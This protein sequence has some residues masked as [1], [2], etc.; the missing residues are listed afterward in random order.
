MAPAWRPPEASDRKWKCE[1]QG[2]R[3]RGKEYKMMTL[4]FERQSDAPSSG[5]QRVWAGLACIGGRSRKEARKMER[6][7]AERVK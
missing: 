4:S 1:Q 3:Q 2:G 7:T 5:V 6:G